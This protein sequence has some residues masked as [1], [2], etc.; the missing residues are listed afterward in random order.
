[1]NNQTFKSWLEKLKTI[2]EEK[3]PKVILNIC[4]DKF[5]WYETPFSKPLRTREELLK[6]WNSILN[7]E[8][9]SFSY[10]ILSVNKNMGMAKW[11]ATFTKLPS[12]EKASFQGIFQVI[13][14]K[15]GKCIE[16]HQWFNT[17]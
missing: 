6:E 16:F 13:L 8:N 9:I 7:Q 1:M 3:T 4:S 2:W 12:K 14:D 5:L 15:E 17:K 11:D 10:K